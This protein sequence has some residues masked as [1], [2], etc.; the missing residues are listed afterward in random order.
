MTLFGMAPCRVETAMMVRSWIACKSYQ[1]HLPLLYVPQRKKLS[2]NNQTN[3]APLTLLLMVGVADLL[4]VLH[5][6]VV[7]TFI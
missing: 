3:K 5:C 7:F 6:Q 4:Y 1:T 2:D